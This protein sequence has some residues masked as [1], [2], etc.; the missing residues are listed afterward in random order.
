MGLAGITFYNAMD[1]CWYQLRLDNGGKGSGNFGHVGRKGLVG[2]SAKTTNTA[3]IKTLG[4]EYTGV[5]GQDAVDLLMRERQGFVR[6]AF[7]REDVGDIALA[8]GEAGREHTEEGFGLAHILRR[9]REEKQSVKGVL[10]SLTEV[11]EKGVLS[12]AD[13]GRWQIDYKG[14]KA[15]IEPKFFGKDFQ[16]LI[17]AFYVD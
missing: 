13:K 9:R 15:V 10:S 14:K 17:T 16:I 12:E 5:K 2:G 8:W 1:G 3:D 6:R 4:K 7:N 11:I